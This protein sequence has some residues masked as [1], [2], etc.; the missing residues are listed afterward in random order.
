[1]PGTSTQQDRWGRVT[2]WRAPLISVLI[3]VWLGLGG[4]FGSL[5]GGLGDV[6]KSG[7]TAY[8]PQGAEA[9]TAIERNEAF[10]AGDAMP[11]ILVY[12]RSGGLTPADRTLIEG[13]AREIRSDL[14][15]A[16]AAPPIG[17]T[18]SSDGDA[19]Q[20]VV[21][22]ATSD[23][24]ALSPSIDRVAELTKT[25]DG[26]S[27]HLA[28]PAGAQA[29]IADALGAIDFTLVLVTSLVIV[30]ILIVVYRSPLL[31]FLVLIVA[32]T[33]L[34]IT[35]GVLYLL[36]DAGVLEMG[37]EVQGILSVLVLGCATDYALLLIA[38]YREEL[39]VREKPFDAMLAAWRA[40]V[41]PI[42]AS[43]GT[44]GLGL[45]CLLVSDLGLNRYLGP[46][47]A[48]GVLCALLAM[49]TFLP[50]LLV[51]FGRAAFWPRHVHRG[52]E[53][54]E[55]AGV[56]SKV[57]GVVDRSPRKIWVG[58]VLLLALLSLGVFRLD[59]GGIPNSEQIATGDVASQEGQKVINAHFPPG[60]GN[61]AIVIA[62]A[63]SA[64]A[65]AAAAEGVAGVARVEPFA[66]SPGGEPVVANGMSRLDVT[67]D[68]AP[69][70]ARA[71][72]TVRDLRTAVHRVDGADAVVGGSTAVD[73]DFN[74][75]AKRDRIVIPLLFAVVFVL[76]ALLL[77]ALVAPLILLAT[78]I[79]S[80]L[81][82]I[83]TSVL[84]FREIFGFPWVDSTYLLHAFV[85]LVALGIDYNIF[86]VSRV[87]EES[88]RHG[89]RKGTLLGLTLTGGVI[90][91]AGVV[92]AATFSALALVPLVLL[93]E[94][95]FTVAFGVLLDTFVVRSLLV[96]ALV[97]D[98]GRWFWWP[99]NLA[100]AAGRS[101]NGSGP[102]GGSVGP[103]ADEPSTGGEKV[104]EVATS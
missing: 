19:A 79:L 49:I 24:D 78:V 46:A 87:R 11:G 26:L 97:L 37:Q 94:L 13:H 54:V 34:G 1:M 51:V 17:P 36:V 62:K 6:S 30:L 90:T 69:D 48:I 7:A 102:P 22:F 91:S 4:V 83:G 58:L 2:R 80:F 44:V 38:R 74:D 61:P 75:A 10:G 47:A 16:L 29:D 63:G 25:G 27:V 5:A 101:R 99:G 66:A 53:T 56:W 65:V 86:L 104:T 67:L 89:L 14:G 73:L 77:R 21:L 60:A 59:S 76:V 12:E 9:T 40:S 88:V 98:T 85:F 20:L 23:R 70:S 92:L 103:G 57:A 18:I 33:A 42:A 8:L 28:G 31:P 100:K 41:A 39:R 71:D 84:V 45:L 50:P 43:A 64:D 55:H 81:A 96:P 35:M 15:D 32:G 93:I 95:A 68:S 3:L 72:Q 52:S 82:S